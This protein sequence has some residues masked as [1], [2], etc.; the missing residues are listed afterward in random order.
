MTWPKWMSKIY[1]NNSTMHLLLAPVRHKLIALRN[2]TDPKNLHQAWG[3]TSIN[4]RLWLIET[5]NELYGDRDDLTILSYGCS[6]GEEVESISLVFK[7]AKIYGKLPKYSAK[8]P[9]ILH[10]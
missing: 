9:T 3:T 8:G 4:R 7:R 5:V 6:T 1:Q 10:K 2:F